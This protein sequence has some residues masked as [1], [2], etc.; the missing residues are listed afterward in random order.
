MLR[1]TALTVVVLLIG[2]V[3]LAQG[4]I[5]DP[6]DS[7]DPRLHDGA[8]FISRVVLGGAIAPVDDYR[9]LHQNAGFVSLANSLYWRHI[10]L[11]Y[12]ISDRSGSNNP[13]SVCGCAGNPIYFPTPPSRDSI[14]AAPPPGVKETVQFA[15]YHTVDGGPAQPPVMLRY[16]LSWSWQT[17]NTDVLSIATGETSH[18]S[19]RERSIGLDA[20]TYFRFRDHDVWGSL[21]FARTVQTGTTDNRAQNALVYESRFP[22][23]T[24][25]PILVRT[26]LTVG[27]V[28]G[29]GAS[30]INIVNPAFEAFWH[31]TKTDVNL[32]LVWSPLAAKSGAQGWLNV[33]QIAF[34]ADYAPVVKLFPA[35]K[36]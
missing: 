12:K 4:P 26:T 11:D 15:W 22:G 28:S 32:H 20:D 18:L 24:I 9:P 3:A 27:G 30:G 2:S 13:V 33:Q 35:Y 10:Q 17:I 5:G 8:L 31:S 29:R 19:G 25:G 23:R 36:E 7:V 6:D 1:H 21:I 34:F 14:P 16:R